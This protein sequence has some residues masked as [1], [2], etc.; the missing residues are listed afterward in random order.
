M[1]E[2]LGGQSDE[3]LN[4]GML[5]L[6]QPQSR[7]RGVINVGTEAQDF[8][9]Q[10][11]VPGEESTETIKLSDYR[12]KTVVLDFWA[13]WCGPCLA[14]LPELV[15]FYE[16]IK[17]NPNAVLLGIS[18]DHNE[19]TLLNFLAKRPEMAWAQLRTDPNSPLAQ[20][21]GIVAVPTLIVIDPEGNVLAI[22]PNMR[23][24]ER[25]VQSR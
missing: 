9:L 4:V 25:F 24:L 14:Q 21:Y 18:I 1:P 15:K 16:T 5:V 13:T 12:G 2:I 6:E 20:Q 22:N 3:P 8:E 11:L 19:K 10:R 7:M 23:E 17:E